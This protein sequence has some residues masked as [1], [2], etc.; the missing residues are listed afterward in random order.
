MAFF[1]GLSGYTAFFPLSHERHG[2]R[3]KV[4]EHEMCVLNFSKTPI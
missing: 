3:E 4:I 2:F 1:G